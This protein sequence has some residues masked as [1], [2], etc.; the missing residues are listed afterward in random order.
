MAF[1]V[2]GKNLVHSK[3]TIKKTVVHL[4]PFTL[5]ILP[6]QCALNFL[7]YQTKTGSEIL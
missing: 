6:Y 2:E 4:K 1:L 3:L 5:F 7:N